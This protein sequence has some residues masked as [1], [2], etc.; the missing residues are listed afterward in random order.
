[1]KKFPLAGLCIFALAH[2]LVCM[3]IT[4]TF[5]ADYTI[6]SD[7]SSITFKVR[8]LAISSVSGRFSEFA[9][10]FSYDPN[11]VT[12]SKT[13]ATIKIK[14][15][16]TEQ[17]K[18]DDH[19]RSPDFFDAA[20]FGEITFKSSAVKNP[21]AEGF[22]LLGDLTMHGVTKPVTLDVTVGGLGKDMYGNERAAFSATTKIDRKDWGLTWSKTLDTGAVVVGDEV[23]V[24]LEIEGIKKKV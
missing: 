18:R 8:H 7:H 17:A 10:M 1:M 5:A 3:P 12:T 14:S 6:D 21:T 2:L 4:K 24:N 13:D 22:Q 20:K 9:G 23:T 15:I 16:N 11:N 19:L